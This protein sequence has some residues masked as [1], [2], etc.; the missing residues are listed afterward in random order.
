MHM[1]L[2]S[3]RWISPRAS[4]PAVH[5]LR[6][7]H[8]IRF[9]HACPAGLRKPCRRVGFANSPNRASC[10]CLPAYCRT[11]EVDE[12]YG[13]Y[14]GRDAGRKATNRRI[15]GTLLII[16]PVLALY[17]ARIFRLMP[18]LVHAVHGLR[19]GL[20]IGTH[21]FVSDGCV[22]NGVCERY[23]LLSPM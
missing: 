10:S 13:A 3:T 8:P 14:M 21:P 2:G 7:I 20:G 19:P 15:V 22:P 6:G 1:H 5:H 12:N 9:Q 4:G 17:I 18:E 23:S 11:C 16:L